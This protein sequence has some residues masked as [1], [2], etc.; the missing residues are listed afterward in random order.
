MNGLRGVVVEWC[1]GSV[2][3]GDDDEVVVPEMDRYDHLCIGGTQPSRNSRVTADWPEHKYFLPG[4]SR[5]VDFKRA[6]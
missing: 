3:S 6:I 1:G 4:A 5:N 2:L